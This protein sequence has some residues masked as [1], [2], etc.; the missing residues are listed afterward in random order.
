[1]PRADRASQAGA[2]GGDPVGDDTADDDRAAGEEAAAGDEPLATDAGAPPRWFEFLV[3]AGVTGALSVG[4]VA[5]VLAI[6][7]AYSLLPALAGAA[8]LWAALLWL[9]WRGLRPL[10][11]ARPGW[12]APTIAAGLA[13]L[14]AVV[15][16]GWYG[17]S[18]SQHL[19]TDRDPAIYVNGA[20]W[21]SNE[22]RL[23]APH[24][25]DALAGVPDVGYNS[26]GVYSTDDGF[27]FQFN[28]FTTALGAVAYDVG[29]HRALFRFTGAVTALGLLA[30]YAVTARALRR[31]FF[32]LVVP[33]VVAASLPL[34]VIARDVYSEPNLLMAA[35][36]AAMLAA[37][38]W[39]RPRRSLAAV[40]GFVVGML[41]VIRVESF[42]YVAGFAA[43]AAFAFVLGRP[44][45]RRVVPFAALAA[46][47]GIAVGLVDFYTLTGGYSSM[48]GGIG[49]QA[50]QAVLFSLV[51]AVAAPLL[52]LVWRRSGALAEGIRRRRAGLGTALGV[53]VAAALGALW[54]VRPLLGADRDSTVRWGVLASIQERE[55]E[56]VDLF[57]SYYEHSVNW[58]AWYV[59]P[60]TV[61][62][63][64]LGLGFMA[65]RLVQGRLDPA[66]TAALALFGTGGLV[67]LV[68]PSIT[69]DQIWATRRLVPIVLVALVLAAAVM[70]ERLIELAP[71]RAGTVLRLGGAGL[72]VVPVALTTGP[73]ALPT[74]Q[75]SMFGTVEE[76]CG[77]VGDDAVALMVDDL[78][79][80]A[81][82][83]PLRSVCDVPVGHITGA[84]VDQS[85]S[86]EA[87]RRRA[88]ELGLDLVLVATDPTSLSPFLDDASGPVESVT[89]PPTR[90]EIER[91]LEGAPTRYMSGDDQFFIPRDLSVYVVHLD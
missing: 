57:R 5:L 21:I 42:L 11:G 43:L 18:P 70:L 61:A 82:M 28:H 45:I 17:F 41:A 81:L 65:A 68:E 40:T 79:Q 15:A 35:W 60:I 25:R 85:T 49:K 63:G 22:G 47:P 26:P 83:P 91:T 30:V 3:A 36:T 86:V 38:L 7:G 69:P 54:L 1:M 4:L 58:V 66:L 56:A 84:E 16:A 6:A 89:I 8:L 34:L 50:T 73:I 10:D 2:P 33:A 74:E 71:D 76:V 13:V 51:V 62:L 48:D 55:G 12:N 37:S 9:L 59:G 31:P 20:I 29:G 78:G 67:Y 32:A 80:V 27:E 88:H 87:A 19:L 53:V 90:R 77:L 64:I 24:A 75:S 14:L 52:L 23:D 39:D 46:L 44:A 72:M